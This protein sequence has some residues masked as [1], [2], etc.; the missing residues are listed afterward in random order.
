MHLNWSWNTK[1]RCVNWKL[2]AINF[3]LLQERLDINVFKEQYE[4]INLWW[5]NFKKINIKSDGYQI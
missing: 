3:I 2:R 5:S 1:F 4:Y